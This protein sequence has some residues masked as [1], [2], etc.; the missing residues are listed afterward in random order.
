L[1][2]SFP[3]V[4][5][6]FCISGFLI[7][8][9]VERNRDDF[10]TYAWSRV[11]RVYPAL[12]VCSTIWLGL[13]LA[14]GVF[15]GVEWWRVVSWYLG[16]AAIGGSGINPDFFRSFGMGVW[17]A[18]LWT[19]GV[20]IAFYVLLPILYL[21]DR[22]GAAFLD[23]IFCVLCLAS[24]ALFLGFNGLNYGDTRHFGGLTKAVWFSLPGNLWMLLF[25]TIIHRQFKRLGPLL[26][27]KVLWWLAG[28]IALV[29][30]TRGLASG[31]G[32]KAIEAAILFIVRLALALLTVSAAFSFRGLGDFLLRG[33][34]ISYGLYVYHLPVYNLFIQYG[35][36]AAQWF[37][38]ALA[39]GILCGCASW[40][41]LECR[42]LGLKD[43][44]RAAVKTD[45]KVKTQETR[46]DILTIG[47]Q[48]GTIE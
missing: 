19:V 18:A 26:S 47:P 16:A 42:M 48:G 11:L 10:K 43:R 9:S 6:F 25:G 44:F 28:Y 30:A 12:I 45:V 37:P 36:G 35:L 23:R 13:M 32:G 8:R 5:S 1:L 29:F 38:L 2:G 15:H 41:F 17:N 24:F 4:Q 46:S 20:E 14:L 7:A 22:W 27:G 31:A 3:G 34:D 33:N 40:I 39:G 21:M